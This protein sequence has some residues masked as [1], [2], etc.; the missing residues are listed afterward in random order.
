MSIRLTLGLSLSS[1]GQMPSKPIAPTLSAATH[2]LDTSFTVNWAA[3][4]GATGYRLDVSTVSNFA[5]F[6]TGYE[7]KEVSGTSAAVTGLALATTYYYRLRAVNSAGTGV[8]SDTG[9]Q[10]TCYSIPIAK[11]G[12]GANAQEFRFGNSVASTITVVLSPEIAGGAIDTIQPYGGASVDIDANSCELPAVA[13]AYSNNIDYVTVTLKGIGDSTG[14][15]ILSNPATIHHIHHNL[16]PNGV[17]PTSSWN[18]ALPSG[19][20]YLYLTINFTYAGALPSAL[21][22]LYLSGATITWAYSGALPTTLTYL[23][24]VGNN[25]DWASSANLPAGLTHINLSGAKLNWTGVLPSSST[26]IDLFTLDNYRLTALTSTELIALLTSMSARA[27]NLPATCT[28]K[29]YDNNPTVGDISAAAPNVA[30]T[31]AEQIKYWLGQV[32]AHANVAKV[33][34]NTTD[35]VD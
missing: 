2:V 19:L 17:A 27:G 25:I 26:A 22:Y 12:T 7:D 23:Y 24:M 11:Y 31:P 20:T 29:E 9:T 18:Y 5:S 21:R 33:V 8:S 13:D 16:A 34:L 35:Y 30:G 4:A 1:G 28:V 6:V 15:I 3:V 10:I 14:R 32:L